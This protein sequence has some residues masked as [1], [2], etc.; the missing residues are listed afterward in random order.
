M[1]EAD[2]TWRYDLR[3]GPPRG[4]LPLTLHVVVTPS[5]IDGQALCPVRS[6][7][8]PQ[9]CLDDYSE[10]A[11]P[12]FV[13]VEESGVPTLPSNIFHIGGSSTTAAES[14]HEEI[15]WKCV[16]TDSCEATHVGAMPECICGSIKAPV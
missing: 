10:N 6:T 16:C 12:A 14:P 4:R 9:L 13:F 11:N 8:A 7:D 3:H 2:G 5:P 15:F 1:R